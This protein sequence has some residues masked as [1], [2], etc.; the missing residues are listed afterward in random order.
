VEK[1]L[2]QKLYPGSSEMARNWPGRVRGIPRMCL[3]GLV[4]CIITF[5]RWHC[6][7]SLHQRPKSAA[8]GMP[9]EVTA[10][11]AAMSKMMRHLKIGPLVRDR[12]RNPH[13]DRRGVAYDVLGAGKAL[14]KRPDKDLRRKLDKLTLVS[15][16]E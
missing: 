14:M 3:T 12:H 2:L 1:D 6:C 9:D 16:I 4:A 5:T 7:Q 8:I 10:Q 15:I 11:E 13:C